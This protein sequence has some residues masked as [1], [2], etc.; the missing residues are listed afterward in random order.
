MAGGNAR[1]NPYPV[2]RA[3]AQRR[4]FPMRYR[5]QIVSIGLGLVGLIVVIAILAVVAVQ[6]DS[7]RNY[8]RR[9]IITAAEDGTGG[10]VEIESFSFSP[11]RLE[12]V[13][14]NFVIHGKEPQGAAP[15]ARASRVQVNVRLLTS[16]RRILDISYLGVERPQAN[17]MV[18]A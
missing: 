2:S 11:R 9:K 13:V 5:K 18:F 15:F 1:G 14:T 17:I 8:V 12:A 7:F 4:C 3:A 10:R 16:L 6:T